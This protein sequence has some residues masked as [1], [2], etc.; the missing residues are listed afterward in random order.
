MTELVEQDNF[1]VIAY[2]ADGTEVKVY[3]RVAFERAASWPDYARWEYDVPEGIDRV[4]TA[5]VREGDT[6]TGIQA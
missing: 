1:Y 3:P 6:V 5:S 4:G 2:R